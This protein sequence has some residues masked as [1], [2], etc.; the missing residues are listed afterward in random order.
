MEPM[1]VDAPQGKVIAVSISA[2]RGIPKTN[3][4]SVRLTADHGIDGDAHAGRDHR[5]VSLLAL[6]SIAT[7]KARGL[8]VGPGAFAENIT[9][10]GVALTGL[11]IG[12]RLKIGACE[13]VVTQIGKECHAPCEIGRRAG[14]C[15]MPREGIFARVVAGGLIVPGDTIEVLPRQPEV[16]H[17][18]EDHVQRERG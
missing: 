1:T 15:V 2:R 17:G 16:P 6:E 13:L 4:P 9:T 18:N 8:N 12:D 14:D 10:Q 5:Q 3:V 7:M 11:A